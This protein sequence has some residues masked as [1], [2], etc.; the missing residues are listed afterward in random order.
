M[1]QHLVSAFFFESRRG[2]FG[3]EKYGFSPDL[4]DKRLGDQ[5]FE[6]IVDKANRS[7]FYSMEFWMKKF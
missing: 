1:S 5:E 4:L 6:Q 2:F 7:L 3:F